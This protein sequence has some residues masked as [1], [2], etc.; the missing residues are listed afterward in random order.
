MADDVDLGGGPTHGPRPDG[1]STMSF[2]SRV[3]VLGGP[4]AVGAFAAVITAT[5][6]LRDPYGSGSYLGCPFRALTGWYCPFCGSTRALHD[7]AHLDVTSAWGMN[8]V[9]V[10]AVPLLVVAWLRWGRRLWDRRA[11]SRVGVSPRAAAMVMAGLLVFGV[12]RNVPALAP[13]LA[14]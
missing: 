6:A 14:P 7:L 11:P 3:S 13:W 2:R 10:V 1:V 9:L 12:L 5:A 8:P 4:A